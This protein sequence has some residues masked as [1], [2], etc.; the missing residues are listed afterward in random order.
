MI[1]IIRH[2]GLAV[3]LIFSLI[4]TGCG[5]EAE[6][7]MGS[8]EVRMHDAPGDYEEVNV[9]IDRVEVNRSEDD[10]GWT[11]ISE[12]EQSYNLLELVNGAYEVLAEAELEEGTYEQIRL[13]LSSEEGNHNVVVDGEAHDLFIP[14]GEQTG[15]KLNVN[16][17]IEE[18]L[19]YVLLL[20]FDADRSVVERGS[21]SEYL[22]KPV[23]RATNEAVTGNIAGTVEP[24]EARSALYAIEDSDTL[25]T[26]YA[27]TSDGTF[28][29]TG[30]EEG[31]YTVAVDPREDR[32]EGTEEEGVEVIVGETTELDTL[33]LQ[34]N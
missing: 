7:N 2:T 17:E 18:G 6:E 25:S 21:G 30:L 32:Y 13:I 5:T 20:D 11:V 12:P 34:E 3:L 4:I 14:S 27:D 8:M 33:E 31:E 24:A 22:L 16:A 23:I 15:V 26:T 10:D 9:T 19:E 29:L 28:Q 1:K